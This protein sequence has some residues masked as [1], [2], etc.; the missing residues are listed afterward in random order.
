MIQRDV[1]P[2]TGAA[3]D[4][5]F[6]SADDLVRL[7]MNEGDR[8]QLQSPSGRY[9]GRLMVAAITPGNLEVHWPEGTV[10]LLAAAIDPDSMEPDY[11]ATVTLA[12][13]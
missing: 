8:V 12:R 2:L 7:R 6:I 1:D 4:A 9:E 3:R 11:N 10:L 5:V 13:V